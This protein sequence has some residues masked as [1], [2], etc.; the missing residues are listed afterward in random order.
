MFGTLRSFWRISIGTTGGRGMDCEAVICEACLW[1]VVGM[2]I[3]GANFLM[4]FGMRPAV[5][6]L[7]EFE[8]LKVAN[9]ANKFLI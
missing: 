5:Y 9:L 3:R 8:M 4:V 7:L 1:K 6:G 2:R